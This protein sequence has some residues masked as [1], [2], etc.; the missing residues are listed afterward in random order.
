M[1]PRPGVKDT[2][3]G[4]IEIKIIVKDKTKKRSSRMRAPTRFVGGIMARRTSSLTPGAGQ[5]TMSPSVSS[6]ELSP[7]EADGEKANVRNK[8]TSFFKFRPSKDELEDNLRKSGIIQKAGTNTKVFNASLDEVM[9]RQKTKYPDLKIPAF[10][11]SLLKQLLADPSTFN[12]AGLFRIS[13]AAVTTQ[14]IRGLVDAGARFRKY[15][16][17]PNSDTFRQRA[18]SLADYQR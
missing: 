12:E 8:L 3:V 7:I 9:S 2:V 6:E 4:A 13:G 1:Y 15:K 17:L 14:R 10:V 18:G 16:Y 11:H 5:G